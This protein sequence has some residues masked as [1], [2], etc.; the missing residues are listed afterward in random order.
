MVSFKTIKM[1]KDSFVDKTVKK[2]ILD[3]VFSVK[4]DS[5]DGYVFLLLEHQSKP[6]YYIY[7]FSLV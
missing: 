7:G 4:F 2:S 5:E 1:E 6:D 3:I